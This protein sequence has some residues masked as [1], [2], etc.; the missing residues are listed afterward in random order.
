MPAAA[1][2]PPPRRTR[3]ACRVLLRAREACT[4]ANRA[5]SVCGRRVTLGGTVYRVW[6][7]CSSVMVWSAPPTSSPTIALVELL[8]AAQCSAVDLRDG[9]V[10][11]GANRFAINLSRR[12]TE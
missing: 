9:A 1:P 12:R 11:H 10:R 6:F 8:S 3:R 5:D 4:C 2:P 7:R